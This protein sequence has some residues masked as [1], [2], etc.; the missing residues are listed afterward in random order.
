M[1]RIKV[2]IRVRPFLP[3]ENNSNTIINIDENNKKNIEISKT[4]KKFQGTFDIVLPSNSSQKDVFNF[5]KPAIKRIY[6]GFNCT[7]LTYGQTGSG[8]T[9]T[10]FGGDWAMNEQTLEYQNRKNFQKDNYNFLLNKELIIDPFAKNNGIIPNLILSLFN[11]FNN[12]HGENDIS[13][14]CSYIQIYN[15]H[16]YDLLIDQKELIKNIQKRRKF[17]LTTLKKK[18]TATQIPVNQSP[19][20]IKYDKKLGVI[21][22]NV[23][24]VKTPSFYEM[25]ELLRKG[26]T[27]RKIRQTNKNEMSSRSHT[28][29]IIKLYNLKN[30]ITSKIKLCDLAGSERYDSG[31]HYK[32]IHINEMCNIN[33]SLS[34]LGKVIHCLGKTKRKINYIPY[35]ESKLTQ[36]LED[37]LGGNSTTYLIATISPSEENF[38]ESLNTLKFA[39][40]AHEVMTQILPNQINNNDFGDKEK[41]ILKLSQEVSELK[42]LLSIRGKRGNLDP[43]Q[44]ELIK[45]KK[46][47]WKLKKFI[48]G[49]DDKVNKVQKLI[50]EN[51]DLKNEIKLLTSVNNIKNEGISNLPTSAFSSESNKS[52]LRGPLINMVRNMKQNTTDFILDNNNN[53]YNN[54]VNNTLSKSRNLTTNN[55]L[56]IKLNLKHIINGNNSSVLSAVG[57]EIVSNNNKK[58]I[59]KDNNG[60]NPYMSASFVPS[61]INGNNKLITNTAEN[62]N[63]INK[64]NT[65]SK[66]MSDILKV[67]GNSDRV[68]NNR[69][70]SNYFRQ[71]NRYPTEK[72]NDF[73]DEKETNYI[74]CLNTMEK[75]NKRKTKSLIDEILSGRNNP[76]NVRSEPKNKFNKYM[77]F[78]Y[79][80]INNI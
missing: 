53:N 59:I 43:I 44:E 80:N 10:M 67:G 11:K 17:I 45:L 65:L 40:R 32:K 39:D 24:E 56:P 26:E 8:K 30:G 72:K 48:K 50:K 47:N 3:N 78:R 19:L 68:Y 42:E 66:N 38:E 46:E 70:L 64:E 27:N 77:G 13:I 61:I 63:I 79:I 4:P 7:I 25:F 35:K 20:K 14:S 54:S 62:Y 6:E 22:E 5:I 29:F 15:E 23:T 1:E 55:L 51:N 73:I 52:A 41:E 34:V 49:N 57:E 31:G 33:K 60:I 69:E 9:Y 74:R 76:N 37:S 71:D 28:V 21:I 18:T 12:S 75:K 58:P 36:I 16:I 2:L